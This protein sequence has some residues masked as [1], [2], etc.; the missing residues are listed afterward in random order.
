VSARI[1][2]RAAQAVLIG[3]AAYYAV[4]GGE[5]SA[6]D[7]AHLDTIA[8]HEVAS[9]AVARS[10]LDS[11]RAHVAALEAD[12]VT[13]ERVARERFG[14]IREGETL[15]RFVRVEKST[16]LPVHSVSVP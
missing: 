8:E 4:W 6:L 16:T 5:Y 11:L 2:R 15:Y 12:P 7:L 13:I 14:M 10:E 1:L 3:V 9:L